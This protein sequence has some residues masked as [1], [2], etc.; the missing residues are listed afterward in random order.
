MKADDQQAIDFLKHLRPDGPWVLTAIIPDGATDTITAR[1]ADA[2]RAFVRT[3]DGKRNI[4]YS[5]NPTRGEMSSKAA[6]KDIARIE[7]LLAD[8]DPKEGEAPEA[9]K[10]RYLAALKDGKPAFTAMVDSGNGLQG[11]WKLVDPIVL[12]DPAAPEWAQVVGDVEARM[13]AQM[14]RLESVAGT[15]NVDRILRLPGTVNIPSR[16]KLRAGRVACPTRLIEFNGATCSLE[17]FPA[18]TAKEEQADNANSASFADTGQFA[19][20]EPDDPRLTGLSAKWIAL[21]RDGTGI[22]ENYGGDRSRALIAFTAECFRAGIAEEV[23]ASLLMRWKIGEHIRD[24]SDVARTLNRTIDKA[25]QFVENSKLFE[26]NEKHCVLPI[27]G[28]TRVATWGEDPEFPGHRTI[29]RFATFSDFRALQDKYRHTIQVEG[30]EKEVPLGSWWIGHPH[31]RQYDG[32][33]RFMP[34]RDEDVVNDAL[35]LWQGFAV[36]PVKPAGKSGEAGCK[37]FLDHGSKIICSGNEDHFDYLIK[38]EAFIVQKR[39]RSEIAVGLRTEG[40]GTGKGIWARIL[41]HLYGQHAMEIRNPEHVIG[42]HNPHLEKMLRLTADESLFA[43][44]PKHR[45]ALYNLITEPHLTIEPKFVDV[46]QARNYLNLD[47]LS[48]AA[49]FLPVSGSARRFFAP[50]VSQDKANDHAYFGKIF[51]QMQNGGYEALL[52]HLLHEIDLSDFN[53][54]DVPKTAELAE[55]A[56][57]SRKGVDLLVE[58]ACNDAIAPCQNGAPAG[59]SVCATNPN[60]VGHLRHGLDHTINHHADRNMSRLGALT[61]KRRLAKEWGCVTGNASRLTVNGTQEHCVRWPPLGDLRAKFE[62]KYGK[63]DWTHDVTEWLG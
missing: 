46:Y 15:Q 11:L 9:A 36:S 16:A 14:E 49:H 42:K 20:V 1:D 7:Y 60:L 22:A 12:P 18:A 19:N 59:V 33:M 52:Y 62:A 40:E 55:Q 30:G 24:Q 4:Y 2:V 47:L 45:N 54:R 21:G 23:V 57:Y 29:I 8:L 58:I 44:D 6:K 17:D 41:N 39:T 10:A 38:R 5:V 53:V 25:Q 27:S 61:V 32:G 3:H 35:N 63:Q 43:S 13:K 26:M 50:T 28:K 37:L 51:A 48:N 34:E 56:A 31:R